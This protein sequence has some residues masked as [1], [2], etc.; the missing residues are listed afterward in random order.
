MT[1]IGLAKTD[2]DTPFLWI[3]LDVLEA[4]IS[5]LADHFKTASINW[6]PHT[7]G[8]KIPAIMHKTVAA[9]AIGVTCA[10][11]GEAE[12]M[13]AS[14]IEDILIANQI[15]GPHKIRRLV[16]LCRRADVKVSVDNADNVA[17][18]GAA[19]TKAGVEI[20]VVVD[21]NSG[22]N[23]AGVA[24]GKPT[25]EL[26]RQVAQTEGLRYV[27]LM[28]WEGHVLANPDP[29]IR[30]KGI[31]ESM[32]L[33]GESVEMC[34]EDGLSVEIVSGGGSGTSNVTPFLGVIT[35]IQAGGAILC[36]ARY[37]SWGVISQPSLHVR[38]MVTS[39]PAPNRVILDAGF[40]T[41]PVAH[42]QPEG[43]N[44]PPVE[45]MSASAEHGVVILEQPN[46]SIK[47]GDTFDFIAGY[48]DSTVFLHDNL[49]GVRNGIVESIWPIQARGMLR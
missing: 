3:D 25:L 39:R 40:K 24:P 34:K 17:A 5:R 12:V 32:A 6:R 35:E 44:F 4:N 16:N 38:T 45:R 11:L 46:E 20:S 36:D 22:M 48:G 42:G 37:K 43:V 1:E 9:G 41:L 47:I 2:L 30:R 23:R 33:L 49:Y 18:L 7:K 8:I 26:S 13:V 29:D 31:E 10:K 14:G 27:G 28:S 15:V 19:A 21:V